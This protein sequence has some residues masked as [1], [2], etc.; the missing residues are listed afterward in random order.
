M[1]ASVSSLLC[2]LVST[3]KTAQIE[4]LN[5]LMSHYK[6]TSPSKCLRIAPTLL[7]FSEA[8]PPKK[9][10]YDTLVTVLWNDLRL[11]QSSHMPKTT[12][13]LNQISEKNVNV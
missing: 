4:L 13:H 11:R 12:L 1:R 7:W 8:W 9:T 10:L 3:A 5:G 2:D 6:I